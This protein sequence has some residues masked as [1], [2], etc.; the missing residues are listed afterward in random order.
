MAVQYRVQGIPAS[1]L[2]N[3]EGVIM[4]Q[5]IGPMDESIIQ[6]YMAQVGDVS[7]GAE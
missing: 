7:E 1:F 2:I 6:G 4:D 5:H 3:R